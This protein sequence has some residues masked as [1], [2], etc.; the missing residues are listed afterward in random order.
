LHHQESY[1]EELVYAFTKS[2]KTAEKNMLLLPNSSGF[3]F[4]FV[5]RDWHSKERVPGNGGT[6]KITQGLS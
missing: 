4:K 1:F 2:R 3:A 6:G 5:S